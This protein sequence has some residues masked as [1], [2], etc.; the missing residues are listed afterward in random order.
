MSEEKKNYCIILAG[1]VGRR[2][3]PASSTTL[4]KQFIDFFGAGRSLLQQTFDRFKR[5]LPIDHIFISTY[6]DYVEEVVRQ[7]PELP[8][9][10]VLP[11]PVQLST[12][13]AALWSTY[14]VKALCPGA[15]IVV[16]PADQVIQRE[17]IFERQVEE[18]FRY[19]ETHDEFLALGVHPGVP[20]TAYGYL[21][22][23]EGVNGE[24]FY[25]V[26]SFTEKPAADYAEVFVESGEFLWN[27]G[28]FFWNERTLRNRFCELMGKSEAEIKVQTEA[29]ILQEASKGFDH[30]KE[31]ID[32]VRSYYPTEW[33]RSI[34]LLLLEHC[35]NLAVM[36]CHFGWADI[37]CWSG[38]YEN[39]PKDA[40]GNA[41]AGGGDVMFSGTENTLVSLPKGMTA[42]VNGLKD[43][44][45]AQKDNILLVCPNND[46]ALV[47]R[48]INEAQM[49][50]GE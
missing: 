9:A 27:T 19:V 38:L 8:A 24:G 14:H 49:K 42:V 46:E 22:I 40:D 10:N 20:N 5:I 37:G 25:R 18:G 16:T 3:W 13:P 23:G 35:T 36:E 45:I 1:G 28:I 21:Q 4:P 17:D 15:N 47:R 50:L 30:L 32:R 44:L 12:A 2:L 48:L 26:K 29:K 39:A 7:L 33:P 41:A 43:F 6:E 31:E 11:E 34:D